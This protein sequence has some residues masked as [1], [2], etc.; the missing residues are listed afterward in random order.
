MLAEQK[1]KELISLVDRASKEQ[2]ANLIVD[3][4]PK[5]GVTLIG[6]HNYM[7]LNGTYAESDGSR[8]TFHY[9][10]YDPSGPFQNIPD[11]NKIK[12][13]LFFNNLSV[14]VYEDVFN[15]ER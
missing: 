10:S 4:V 9:R 15:D 12:I 2:N 13:E 8:L 7:L 1:F 6:E 5:M 3:E 14:S 11:V